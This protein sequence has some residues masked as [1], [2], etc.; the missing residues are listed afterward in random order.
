L[1]GVDRERANGIDAKLVDAWLTHGI[2][3]PGV[4]A[5]AK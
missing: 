3:G 5:P 1:H 2:S 4:G